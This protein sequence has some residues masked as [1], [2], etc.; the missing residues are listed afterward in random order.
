MVL[1][2]IITESRFTNTS[3]RIGPLALY[4]M[5]PLARPWLLQWDR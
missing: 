3:H 2:E 1:P 5:T 4:D